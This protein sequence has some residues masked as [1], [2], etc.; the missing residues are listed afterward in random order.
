MVLGAAVHVCWKKAALYFDIEPRYCASTV[1]KTMD[2]REAVA[3]VDENTA[4]VSAIMDTTY[5]GDYEDVQLSTTRVWESTSGYTS[6]PPAE[7]LW[8]PS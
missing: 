5:L 2:P 8:F 7:G 4:L 6:M 3:L 1:E